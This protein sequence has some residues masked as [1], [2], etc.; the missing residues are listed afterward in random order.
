[1]LRFTN[2]V[3]SFSLYGVFVLGT[4][5]VA[6]GADDKNATAGTT[7]QTESNGTRANEQPANAAPVQLGQGTEAQ[8]KH[9]AE[10]TA[11]KSV[12][13]PNNQMG[14]SLQGR[15]RPVAGAGDSSQSDLAP[16]GKSPEEDAR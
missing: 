4:P 1:M 5:C 9:S 8:A 3:I 11:H 7:V 10:A 13:D 12:S 15:T 14:T 2:K 16:A 6:Q